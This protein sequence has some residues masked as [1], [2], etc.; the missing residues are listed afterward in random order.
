MTAYHK[1]WLQFVFPLYIWFI[2]ATI[3][4]LCRYSKWLSNKIGGNVVQVLAILILLA[5]TKIFCI[6]APALLWVILHCV[7]NYQTCTVWYMDGELPYLSSKHG[8][9]IIISSCMCCFFLLFFLY[10]LALLFD[11]LIEKYLTRLRLPKMVDQ[12]QALR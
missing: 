12:I 5:F 1:V 11:P 10:T 3:I 9:L 6:F 4:I 8:V 2:I 7:N